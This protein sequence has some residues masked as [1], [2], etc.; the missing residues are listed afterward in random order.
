MI[1]LFKLKNWGFCLSLENNFLNMASITQYQY[2]VAVDTYRHFATAADKCF[3]SQPTL[4]MQIKKLEQ[5]LDVVIF[6][7]TK[8]PVLPT[9]VGR[10]I[11]EQA[12]KILSEDKKVKELINFHHNEI[13]GSLKIGIIPTLANTVIPRF[14][15]TFTR[16]YPQ[17]CLEIEELKTEQILER[18]NKDLIDVGILVTP[19]PNEVTITTIPVFY[20]DIKIYVNKTHDLFSKEQINTTDLDTEDLWLLN[21][22]NCFQ[23]QVINLCAHR[24]ADNNHTGCEYKYQSSSFETLIKM[25]DREG[26]FTL[27]PELTVLDLEDSKLKH[28][29][30]FSDFTP[31]REVSIAVSRNFSKERLVSLLEECLKSVVSPVMHYRER[32]QIVEWK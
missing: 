27:L 28:I 17:V 4:S 14:L 3:V 7:R 10:K 13:S 2:I 8:Q 22:G 29:K 30:E 18:L 31:L 25:I 15:G 21:T 16:K 6:D 12:R 5:E 24:G 26:G 9:D 23:S 20:E 11:I 32:G 19:L 1:Q